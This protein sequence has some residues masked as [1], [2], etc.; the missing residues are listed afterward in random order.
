MMKRKTNQFGQFEIVMLIFLGLTTL[1]ALFLSFYMELVPYRSIFSGIDYVI[2]SGVSITVIF[3]VTFNAAKLGITWILAYMK[4]S[5]KNPLSAAAVRAVL[6]CNSLLMTLFIVTGQ[7]TAPNVEKVYNKKIRKIEQHF[8]DQGHTAQVN[9]RSFLDQIKNSY[10]LEIEEIRNLYQ[11]DLD[12]AESGRKY[13]MANVVNGV[14]KGDRYNEWDGKY[15]SAKRKIDKALSQALGRYQEA[16]AVQN[17]RYEQKQEAIANAKQQALENESIEKY[18]NSYESQNRLVTA[19]MG[20]INK[21]I[22]LTI[23]PHH[24]TLLVA[25]LM[26]A[27]VE[28]VPLLLGSHI[29]TRILSIKRQDN[30]LELL[31]APSADRF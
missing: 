4:V 18:L 26:T 11:P 9:H 21:S 8:F 17:Q 31:P 22:G 16:V 15:D 3:A 13:E 23:G 2:I 20:L 30:R 6:I 27:I 24:I 10:Y 28:F 1:S 14:W 19:F 5:G 29:F 12:K 7:F 25:T